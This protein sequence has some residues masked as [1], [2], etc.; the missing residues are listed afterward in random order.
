[1]SELKRT[2]L[3]D[4]HVRSGATMVDFGGWEMPIQYP[5]GIVAEHL[6]TRSCCSLFD[7]SHMGRLIVEGPERVAFLQHVLSSNV[8]ALEVNRAQYCI[9]PTE[10]GGAVDDA[11]LYRFE[12]DRFLLVVNAANT[13]KDLAYLS[14]IVKK[15]DCVIR[16]IT[17][18][19]VSIAVQG[20]KSAEMLSVLS[21]GV[22]V[23][24]PKRNSLSTMMLEGREVRIARTGYTAEPVGY[25]LFLKNEDAEW[26]W[27]RLVGL[28][29]KPAGLGA[30]DTLRTEGMLPLYGDEMGTD[31]EGNPMPIFALSL[32][33][34]AVSFDESKGDFVG[35]KALLKQSEAQAAFRSGSFTREA[36]DVLPKQVRP[37]ALIDRGVMRHGMEIYRNGEM[38]GWVTSGT[39]IPYYLTE[40][41]GADVRLLPET[42]KRAIGI[43]YI[44]SD[45][46]VNGEVE[47]DVRGRRLRA[48][49][50]QKHLINNVPPYAVPVIAK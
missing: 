13:D 21:G 36:M 3:Y 31:V 10:D 37:I 9:I 23:T 42:G 14:P 26:A 30:R 11:Y 22:E 28:G 47:V 40:G 27:D 49:I 19:T 24:G 2:L 15:Y 12:E 35:R 34:F 48:V 41:E 16:I 50:P 17:N 29:A 43:A 44:S 1:M 18:E 46:P 25:E 8:S 32:A 38:I 20:P 4:V 45:V 5:E 6:Y 39:M 33:K 7:V